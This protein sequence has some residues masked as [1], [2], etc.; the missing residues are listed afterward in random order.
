MNGSAITVDAAIVELRPLEWDTRFFGA[1]MGTLACIAADPSA[2]SLTRALQNQLAEARAE[3][4]AHLIFRAGVEDLPAIRA[5]EN[6][7]LHLVDVGVDSTIVLRD[8]QA[9][10][11]PSNVRPYRDADLATLRGL[12]EA[13]FTLSRFS[14]D[15]FFSEQQVRN[16]HSTWA[17]NLCSGGLA[18]AVLVAQVGA[19]IAGFVA[20]NTTGDEGRIVLIATASGLRGQGVGRALVAASLR[21]FVDAGSRRA[22]VKTQAHNYSALALYHRT[23]FNVSK[24]ELT[25]SVSLQP[26]TF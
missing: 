17:N 8:N 5:A 12:A 13:S 10:P 4:Y 14:A 19:A 16:F 20:C 24:T 1:R 6:A 22:H 18:K 15:P 26:A 7:G 25:F 2:E 21:W 3:G 23:G 11:A 9:P